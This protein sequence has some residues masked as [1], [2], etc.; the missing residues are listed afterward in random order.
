ME[1]IVRERLTEHNRTGKLPF[2]PVWHVA[3]LNKAFRRAHASG[4][5]APDA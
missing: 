4:G 2:L 1:Q 5:F 3:T